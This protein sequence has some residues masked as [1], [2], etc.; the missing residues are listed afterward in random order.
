MRLGAEYMKG[1]EEERNKIRRKREN[2]LKKEM[3][4]KKRLI[5]I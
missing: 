3:T 1:R 5:R 4:K 2:A